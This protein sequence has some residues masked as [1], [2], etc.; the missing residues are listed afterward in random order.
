[1]ATSALPNAFVLYDMHGDVWEWT[2]DCYVN[3]YAGAPTDGSARSSG[4]GCSASTARQDSCARILLHL[5]T[6]VRIRGYFHGGGDA[7]RTGQ[8]DAKLIHN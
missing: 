4:V 6:A 8:D 5:L 1:M 7:H 2:E 3:T